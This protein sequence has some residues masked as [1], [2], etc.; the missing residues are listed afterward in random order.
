MSSVSRPMSAPF[1]MKS[2]LWMCR[3]TPS[4][5]GVTLV[6][7]SGMAACGTRT[8]GMTSLQGLSSRRSCEA[9]PSQAAVHC[10]DQVLS[11]PSRMSGRPARRLPRANGRAQPE[12]PTPPHKP[13]AEGLARR[14]RV[15]VQ[16][17]KLLNDARI[18]FTTGNPLPKRLIRVRRQDAFRVIDHLLF[19][20]IR[21]PLPFGALL[22]DAQLLQIGQGA[23][24]G[25]LQAGP[26]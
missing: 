12:R 23:L 4:M 26:V 3:R 11:L 14:L 18:V 20:E 21:H 7:R 6:A 5:L 2:A 10:S 9:K 15:A 19:A 22:Q 16:I 8:A 13:L 1:R 24:V 17:E 25:T